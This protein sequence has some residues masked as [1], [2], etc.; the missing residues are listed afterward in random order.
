MCVSKSTPAGSIALLPSWGWKEQPMRGSCLMV[1]SVLILK[2]IVLV[3]FLF[4][5]G[6]ICCDPGHIYASVYEPLN[7]Y[8]PWNLLPY[9]FIDLKVGRARQSKDVDVSKVY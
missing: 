3:W 4:G 9:S 8:W 7:H 2:V 6:F 1:S 5:K